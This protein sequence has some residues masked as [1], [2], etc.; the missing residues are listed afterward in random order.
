MV[1]LQGLK[2]Y[3]VYEGYMNLKAKLGR[4]IK[5]LRKRANFSQ[6][7]LAEKLGIAQNTLS[8]IETGENF[9]TAETLEH[10]TN[11]LK[12]TPNELFDF[13]H[14]SERKNIIEE[15]NCYFERIQ[16][17]SDKLLILYKIVKALEK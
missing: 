11:V 14:F 13:E 1:I 9:L 4:R 17:D 3:I 5:E 12:V 7:Q 15:I 10:L 8:K 16:N 2:M 6:E